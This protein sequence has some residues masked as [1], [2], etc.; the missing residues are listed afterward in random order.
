ML[1]HGPL[2]ND[3]MSFHLWKLS[4]LQCKDYHIADRIVPSLLHCIPGHLWSTNIILVPISL[5]LNG[6]P[7]SPFSL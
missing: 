7:D 2:C 5:R 4:D 6:N 1:S 3:Q